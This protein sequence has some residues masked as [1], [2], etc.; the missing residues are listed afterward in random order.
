MWSEHCSYKSSRAHLRQFAEKA[1]QTDVL[2]AGIG[3]NAGVVD[4]GQGYAVTFKIESHNHPPTWSPS[5]ARRR[6]WAASS[7]TFSRWAHGPSR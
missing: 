5:R 2:L 3:Q 1:P 6:A 4:I 7:A